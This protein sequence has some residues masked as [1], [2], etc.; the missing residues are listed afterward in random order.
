M[1]NSIV[2]NLIGVAFVIG[3]VRVTSVPCEKYRVMQIHSDS[4]SAL[5]RNM[6]LSY[7]HRSFVCKT[8]LHLHISLVIVIDSTP[9]YTIRSAVSQSTPAYQLFLN[10]C[11][12]HYQY[13]FYLRV[14]CPNFYLLVKNAH[15]FG[16][17]TSLLAPCGME[18]GFS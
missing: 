11:A 7:I 10:R 2:N 9:A 15:P 13:L 14:H 18:N 12:Y 3:P 1:Q 16:L 6:A 5:F 8:E 17:T 4:R